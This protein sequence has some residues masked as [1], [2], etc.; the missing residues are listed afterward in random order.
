MKNSILIIGANG[1]IGRQTVE[2]ALAA[3]FRVTAIVRDPSRLP[4]THPELEI[5]KG[6]ILEP[7]GFQAH[8]RDKVAVVSA[9]GVKSGLTTDEPTTLYSQ[10]NYRLLEAMRQAGVTRVFFISA[11]AVEISPL[12]PFMVRFLA[13]YA[14]QKLLR[15]MYADLRAMER[16]VRESD[17]NWTI[18]RPPRLTDKPLTG[19]Y[20]WSVNGFL[21]NCLSISRADVAHFILHHITDESTYKG[22]VEIGY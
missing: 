19:R 22:V 18:V 11:S 20:R 1:G 14:L 7:M 15:H 8:L 21:H 4:L 5:V 16:L 9:I 10:G 6:D 2:T 13:K 12:L 17:A 3:G